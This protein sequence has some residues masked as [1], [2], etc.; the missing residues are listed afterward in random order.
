MSPF[1]PRLVL[2]HKRAASRF[3]SL[4]DA[5]KQRQIMIYILIVSLVLA[6]FLIRSGPANFVNSD[7]VSY[8]KMVQVFRGHGSLTDIPTA[9]RYRI[10]CPALAS[11]LPYTPFFSLRLVSL[12]FAIPTGIILIRYLEQLGFTRQNVLLGGFLFF[13]STPFT[14]W[15]TQ[16]LTDTSGLFFIVLTLYGLV[17]KWNMFYILLIISVGALTRETI[18]F[19]IFS[20]YLVL[21]GRAE[22]YKVQIQKTFIVLSGLIPISVEVLTRYIINGGISSVSGSIPIPKIYFVLHNLN[23]ELTNEFYIALLIFLPFLFL[24]LLRRTVFQQ[25]LCRARLRRIEDKFLRNTSVGPILMMLYVF[26]AGWLDGRQV[27]VL[28]PIL[29]PLALLEYERLGALSKSRAEVKKPHLG[30][31]YI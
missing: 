16:P 20:F 31:G 8:E 23:L 28:Y 12:I 29:I 18:L 2:R 11:V 3:W 10:M 17:R 4:V 24:A 22:G 1:I 26:F 7:I 14:I 27:W 5:L 15:G 21:F 9:F 6:I 25:L 19:M 13:F 30:E